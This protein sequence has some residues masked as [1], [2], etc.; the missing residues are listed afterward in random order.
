MDVIDWTCDTCHG[1]TSGAGAISI[2]Y[3]HIRGAEAARKTVTDQPENADFTH[4]TVGDVLARPQL[5]LWKVECNTCAGECI[6]GYW[7]DLTKART[8]TDLADWT[9]HLS[10]K[11]WFTATNWTALVASVTVTRQ[12][13]S[14]V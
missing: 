6:G 1:P 4:L 10:S 11:T 3:E 14:T 13:R 12:A 2:D 9:R 7:I 5:G 8:V